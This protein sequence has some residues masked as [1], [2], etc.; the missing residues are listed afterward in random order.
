MKNILDYNI[1]LLINYQISFL[2]LNFTFDRSIFIY[3]TYKFHIMFVYKL[4][5]KSNNNLHFVILKRLIL[6]AAALSQNL[7]ISLETFGTKIIK[8]TLVERHKEVVSNDNY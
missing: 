3:Y 5:N 4:I 6:L 7:H 1:N 8:V 2:T